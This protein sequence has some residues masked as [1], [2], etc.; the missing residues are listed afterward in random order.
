MSKDFKHLPLCSL[1]SRSS[2]PLLSFS[3]SRRGTYVKFPAPAAQCLPRSNLD[4]WWSFPLFTGNK[5]KAVLFTWCSSAALM[6]H[7][8][9][10]WSSDS[11]YWEEKFLSVYPS[12]WLPRGCVGSG[13]LPSSQLTAPCAL[14]T[15]CTHGAP[16][17]LHTFQKMKQRNTVH[18]N[19]LLYTIF[20]D[21]PHCWNKDF[22]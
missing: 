11:S 8:S 2:L 20:K 1:S 15:I 6:A 10:G 4:L 13:N 9:K 3:I 16:C 19:K 12:G 7:E 22:L 5:T 14:V 18:P 17:Y 21:I